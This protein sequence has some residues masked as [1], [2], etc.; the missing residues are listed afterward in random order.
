MTRRNPFRLVG[1]RYLSRISCRRISSKTPDVR[2]FILVSAG[3]WPV[4]RQIAGDPQGKEVNSL[5][6]SLKKRPETESKQYA[7]SQKISSFT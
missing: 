2:N 7:G 3:V 1:D 4:I 5:V 6:E